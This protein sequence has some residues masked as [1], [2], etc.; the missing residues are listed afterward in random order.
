MEGHG[1]G[2]GFSIDVHGETVRGAAGEDWIALD[3]DGDGAWSDTEVFAKRDRTMIELEDGTPIEFRASGETLGHQI[4]E[5]WTIN[6]RIDGEP[7]DLAFLFFSGGSIIARDSDRDGNYETPVP[8][9]D[10]IAA[11][12][13]AW[14][15]EVD[16]STHSVVLR[17]SDVDPVASGFAAPDFAAT[18]EGTEELFRLEDRRG[19]GTLLVFCHPGCA[20]CQQLIPELAALHEKLGVDDPTRVVGV[21]RD[22]AHAKGF[23]IGWDVVVSDETWQRYHVAPTPTLVYVDGDGVIRYRGDHGDDA[24]RALLSDG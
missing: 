17:P 24:W 4:M 14:R 11:G 18:I 3:L 23:P 19:H 13:R 8:S 2:R 7:L 16:V 15:F 12:G 22:A 1:E 5:V 21:L 10:A 9:T 6:D 20:G